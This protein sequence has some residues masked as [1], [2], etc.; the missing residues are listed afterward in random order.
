[1]K[2]I[3]R[4]ILKESEDG[5]EWAED[6]LRASNLELQEIAKEVIQ[7]FDGWTVNVDG[8]GIT[9]IN[10]NIV[11]KK[12]GSVAKFFIPFDLTTEGLSGKFP[13]YFYNSDN[14]LTP[15]NCYDRRCVMS[16]NN[17]SYYMRDRQLT[18]YESFEKVLDDINLLLI[19]NWRYFSFLQDYKNKT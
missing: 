14:Q 15:V 7:P 9:F 2:K 8:V 19:N 18:K 1:M 17:S 5:F 12:N 13:V 4:K 16:T 3:I 11:H 6:S 10:G